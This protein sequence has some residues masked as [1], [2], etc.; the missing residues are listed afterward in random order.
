MQYIQFLE[1]YYGK[2]VHQYALVNGVGHNATGIFFSSTALK[3]IFDLEDEEVD[4]HPQMLQKLVQEYPHILAHI[5][6]QA[7]EDEADDPEDAD[8]F[9]IM[10]HDDE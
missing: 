4:A 1:N 6:S 9:R 3:H 7:G 10:M 8:E 5:T 2:P